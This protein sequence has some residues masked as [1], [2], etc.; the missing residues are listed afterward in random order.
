MKIKIKYSA[1]QSLEIMTFR[2]LKTLVFDKFFKK[3]QYYLKFYFWRVLLL[4]ANPTPFMIIRLC[5]PYKLIPQ[6]ISAKLTWPQKILEILSD[7]LPSHSPLTPTPTALIEGERCHGVLK[8]DFIWR[9]DVMNWS[10]VGTK[11]VWIR[12]RYNWIFITYFLFPY[13]MNSIYSSNDI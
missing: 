13:L 3:L 5:P 8:R 7:S 6:F 2:Y 12:R 4:I 11:K 9:K 10:F 1:G